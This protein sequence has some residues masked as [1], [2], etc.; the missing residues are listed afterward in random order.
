MYLP[1]PS[2]DGTTSAVDGRVTRTIIPTVVHP[3]CKR[4]IQVVGDGRILSLLGHSQENDPSSGVV[5]RKG[6]RIRLRQG[7]GFKGVITERARFGGRRHPQLMVGSATTNLG[8]GRRRSLERRKQVGSQR[9]QKTPKLAGVIFTVT[10]D[11]TLAGVGT[12]TV[13]SVSAARRQITTRKI[14]L[15]NRF[16]MAILVLY[17]LRLCWWILLAIKF[18]IENPTWLW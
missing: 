17:K 5:V 2:F 8:Y 16:I 7:K 1:T 13:F 15:S 10:L 18:N 4:H 3:L 14:A 6:I 11:S 9:Y 12:L